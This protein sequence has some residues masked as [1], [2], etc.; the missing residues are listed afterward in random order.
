MKTYGD[1]EVGLHAFH[2]SVR[3]ER[4]IVT[5]PSG[6]WEPKGRVLGTHRAASWAVERAS[7]E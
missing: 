3:N 6:S 4:E 2:E 1:V 5:S 7:D